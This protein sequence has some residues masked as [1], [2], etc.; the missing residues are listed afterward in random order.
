MPDGRLRL[1]A[2]VCGLLLAVEAV[3]IAV[4][5]PLVHDVPLPAVV[6]LRGADGVP[7]RVLLAT[8]SPGWAA[9]I[10]LALGAVARLAVVPRRTAEKDAAALARNRHPARWWEWSFTLPITVFL[11]AQLNGISEVPALVL[12]YAATA[13]AVLTAA[14]QELVPAGR[15]QPLMLAAAV[16]IVPWGV[17]AFVQVGAGLAGHP[18]SGAVRVLTLVEL[19]CAAAFLLVVWR[20]QARAGRGAR[21]DRAER[22]VVLLGTVALSAFAW[23][24]VFAA[25]LPV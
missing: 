8:V 16:G 5:L 24:V 7:V 15:R 6:D 10:L 20:E 1:T 13:G 22:A 4:L 17:I 9:V 11:V 18:P 21:D 25:A 3:V 19:V 14:L 2:A 12:V 23:L